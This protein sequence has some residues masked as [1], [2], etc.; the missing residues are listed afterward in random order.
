MGAGPGATLAPPPGGRAYLPGPSFLRIAGAPSPAAS[1]PLSVHLPL[2]LCLLFSLPLPLVDS[3]VTTPKEP[4]GAAPPVVPKVEGRSTERAAVGCR[5]RVQR[6]AV[7][8]P[9]PTGGGRASRVAAARLRDC[10]LAVQS[11]GAG[12]AWKKLKSKKRHWNRS[13][14]RNLGYTLLKFQFLSEGR[15]FRVSCNHQV[16]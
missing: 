12:R 16:Y 14:P 13:L 10:S 7:S 2:S 15:N 1:G 8:Q 4:S 6:L 9:R 11:L 3:V 5:S